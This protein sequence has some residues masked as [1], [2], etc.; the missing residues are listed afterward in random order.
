M[1]HETG[2][3][4]FDCPFS[5]ELDEYPD[6]F[7]VYKL[8]EKVSL[9]NAPSWNELH[10][11]GKHIGSIRIEG[12]IVDESKRKSIL[13]DVLTS[14]LT[15]QKRSVRSHCSPTPLRSPHSRR[16]WSLSVR[17]AATESP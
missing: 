9:G 6:D 10:K 4:F 17:S 13:G 15:K 3:Y 5:D 11:Y 2:S 7:T 14:L 12:V 8:R 1:N 16:N